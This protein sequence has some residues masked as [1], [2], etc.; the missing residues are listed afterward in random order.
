MEEAKQFGVRICDWL[1]NHYLVTTGDHYRITKDEMDKI[2]KGEIPGET[3]PESVDR[4][5][6]EYRQREGISN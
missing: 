2:R 1:M 5:V 4:L 3:F 6:S